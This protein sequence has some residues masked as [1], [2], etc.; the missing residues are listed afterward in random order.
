MRLAAGKGKRD[1]EARQRDD[2]YYRDEGYYRGGGYRPDDYRRDDN[3]RDDYRYGR[4]S[5]DY[6]GSY[7]GSGR[8]IDGAVDRCLG[9]VERG[10][11]RV[12]T[13]EL[14]GRDGDGWRV[15]GRVS[16]GQPFECVVD[17]QGRVRGVSIDGRGLS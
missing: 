1:R 15:Q 11:T 4:G 5:N 13:V 14:S 10:S 12:D 8:N 2:G 6:R 3:R 16:G 9:E 7:S 17:G